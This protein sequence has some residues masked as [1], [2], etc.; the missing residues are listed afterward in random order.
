[1]YAPTT[2]GSLTTTSGLSSAILRP[3][4]STTRRCEKLITALHDVLDHD[5]RD[6]LFVEA[7]QQRQDVLDF[8]MR[9]A[10]HRLVGDQKLRLGR[11]GAG[12]LELAHLHLGQ[13][14]RQLVR[15]IVEA[16]HLQQ[17]VTALGEIAGASEAS[18]DRACTV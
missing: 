14:A 7:N 12:E 15:L 16:H 4:T 9:Q 2:S 1:M 18:P 17:V 3:E 11:H 8:R 10:G 5:H 13:V 6:A